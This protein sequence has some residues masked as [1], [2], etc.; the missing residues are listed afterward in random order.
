MMLI[1]WHEWNMMKTS[2][3]KMKDMTKRTMKI[4]MKTSRMISTIE[5]TKMKY[6]VE[7]LN[8][9]AREEDNPNQH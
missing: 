9:N 5:L 2:N 1:G 7:D 8:E 4:L 3:K 6:E